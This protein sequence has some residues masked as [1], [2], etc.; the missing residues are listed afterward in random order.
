MASSDPFALDVRELARSIFDRA[1]TAPVLAVVTAVIAAVAR[2]G[3]ELSALVGLAGRG[4]AEWL[5]LVL[6]FSATALASAA[7]VSAGQLQG[8][9]V[10]AFPVGVIVAG[11]GIYVVSKGVAY[12][13]N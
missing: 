10:L 7:D 2:F 1:V 6:G 11:V 13:V 5:D 9:E 3:E 4:P 12:L 8:L